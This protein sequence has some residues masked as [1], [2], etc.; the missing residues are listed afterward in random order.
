MI[1][2]GLALII[3]HIQFQKHR[4]DLAEH[5]RLN[6]PRPD[7]ALLEARRFQSEVRP[8]WT[9]V[10]VQKVNYYLSVKIAVL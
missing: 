9:T 3:G 4:P 6:C 5:I 10:D 1:S 2:E 8:D 7:D